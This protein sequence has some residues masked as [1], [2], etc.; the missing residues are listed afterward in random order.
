MSIITLE[1]AKLHIR[2]DHDTEDDAIQA[3]IDAAEAAALDYLN[4]EEL[5]EAAPVQAATLMLVGTLY[6]NRESQSERP[7]V[8]NYLFT[9]LL[10]PYRTMEA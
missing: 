4:L 2:V 7:I 9:R 1:Q 3:M 8:E 5:P 6:A 10:A